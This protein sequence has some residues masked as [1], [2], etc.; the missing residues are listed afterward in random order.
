MLTQLQEVGSRCWRRSFVQKERWLL[1]SLH[2][3]C[4]FYRVRSDLPFLLTFIAPTMSA[5]FSY[6]Q[7]MQR[8]CDF[9]TYINP[10]GTIVLIK[11]EFV[12][13]HVL[14]RIFLQNSRLT[15]LDQPIEILLKTLR[16]QKCQ[17][18]RVC[19]T[20]PFLKSLNQRNDKRVAAAEALSQH[21]VLTALLSARG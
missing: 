4:A 10:I 19:R 3:R 2:E 12:A 15:V 13:L 20:Q 1:R 11:Q 5:L 6:P 18:L 17:P 14:Q 9:S 21:S 16:L 7:P 8:N